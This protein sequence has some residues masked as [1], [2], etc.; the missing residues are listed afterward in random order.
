MNRQATLLPAMGSRLHP[1]VCLGNRLTLI[2]FWPCR[3]A[4][5]TATLFSPATQLYLMFVM[6]QKDEGFEPLNIQKPLRTWE[7]TILYEGDKA[8]EGSSEIWMIW[9]VCQID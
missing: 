6:C 5:M 3:E 1:L 8:G 9:E 4:S 2:G 7:L